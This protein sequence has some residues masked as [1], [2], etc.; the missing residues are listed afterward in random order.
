MNLTKL[1][2]ELVADEGER[3]YAYQDTRELW[4]IGVGQL[5]DHRAGGGISRAASRFMLQERIDV[6]IKALNA[7]IPWW[8]NLSDPRRRVLVNMAYNL[9]VDGLMGFVATLD[10]IQHG[11]YDDAARHLLNSAAARQTSG[12][13]DST[14]TRY[15]RLAMMMRDG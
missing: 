2:D 10:A 7:R 15:G 11:Q 9:G 4:T 12:H 1:Q 5:I 13:H 6:I 8:I 14:D 3:L